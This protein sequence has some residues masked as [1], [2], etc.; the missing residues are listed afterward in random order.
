MPRK[1]TAPTPYPKQLYRCL[2]ETAFTNITAEESRRFG[3]GQIVDLS[4]ILD[5][6]TTLMSNLRDLSCWQKL[7]GDVAPPPPKIPKDSEDAS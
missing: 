5:D 2:T 1:K 6:G 3:K 7:E 4:V